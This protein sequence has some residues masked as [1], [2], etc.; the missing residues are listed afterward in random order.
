MAALWPVSVSRTAP[1]AQS[2]TG[3]FMTVVTKQVRAPLSHV[4]V[5]VEESEGVRQQ[6]TDWRMQDE[7]IVPLLARTP[8]ARTRPSKIVQVGVP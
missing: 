1:R 6:G 8:T 7:T 3:A 4:S 5:D 2:V